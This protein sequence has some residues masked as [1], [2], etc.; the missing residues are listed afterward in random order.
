[1]LRREEHF[2]KPYGVGVSMAPYRDRVRWVT[3]RGEI[4][5]E[6]P[7][8]GRGSKAAVNEEDGR[9]GSVMMGWCGTEELKVSPRSI[10]ISARYGRV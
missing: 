9:F 6:E 5:Q 2:P 3:T 8:F 7:V 4:L 1:M 10:D